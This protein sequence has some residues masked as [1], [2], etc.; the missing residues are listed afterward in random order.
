MVLWSAPGSWS[1]VVTAEELEGQKEDEWEVP[2]VL[3]W[4]W[5]WGS[6]RVRECPRGVES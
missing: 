4:L 5:A 2:T 1:G 3:G 6:V